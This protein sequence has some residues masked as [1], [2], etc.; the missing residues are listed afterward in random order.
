MVTPASVGINWIIK[1]TSSIDTETSDN[2]YA[3]IREEDKYKTTEV[4][5]GKTWIDGKPI[6][7]IVHKFWE[8]GVVSSDFSLSG[9]IFTKISGNITDNADEI[10]S[11]KTV[12]TETNGHKGEQHSSNPGSGIGT[13]WIS[14][15]SFY[16]NIGV[17]CESEYLIIEY[18]KTTD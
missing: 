2:V 1:A 12:F 9:Q 6:Y 8:N 13:I 7:R 5:T 3:T 10:I 16:N 11:I 18:T 15:N 17:T 4:N 14:N